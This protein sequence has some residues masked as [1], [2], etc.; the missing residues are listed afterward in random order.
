[1]TEI[2]KRN[3]DTGSAITQ[4]LPDWM[5]KVREA[6]TG[7]IKSEDLQAIF[8]KQVELAKSGDRKAAAFV[9]DQARLFSEVK[10][11]TLNQTVNHFHGGDSPQAKTSAVPGTDR[12]IERMRARA[13]MGEPLTRGDDGPEANLD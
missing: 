6:V 10:G 12:K 9:L 4:A 7:A 8:A 11:I 2:T 1:M 3:A 5:V 13:A